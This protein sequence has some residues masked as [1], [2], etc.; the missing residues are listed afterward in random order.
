MLTA[1]TEFRLLQRYT[2]W[3]N[4]GTAPLPM[5]KRDGKTIVSPPSSPDGRTARAVAD[6]RQQGNIA[7]GRPSREHHMK[8][9]TPRPI[10]I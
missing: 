10:L 8:K 9:K 5:M 4:V 3:A 7:P 2:G 6:H 1:A